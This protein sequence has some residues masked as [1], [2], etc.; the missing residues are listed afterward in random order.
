MKQLTVFALLMAQFIQAGAQNSYT[1]HYQKAKA[2]ITAM[3][4]GQKPL[5]FEK[6]VFLMENAYYDNSIEYADFEVVLDGYVQDVKLIA[7]QTGR[8]KVKESKNFTTTTEQYQQMQDKAAD[9]FAIFRFMTDTSFRL[10]SLDSTRLHFLLQRRLPF[11]YP[12]YDPLGSND[13]KNTQVLNLAINKTGNCFALSALFKMLADRLHTG[14][15]LCTAPGHIYIRHADEKGT[16]FNVELAT[17]SFPGTGSLMTLTY[18]TT[19][20][21]KSGIALRQL[22]EKQSVAL[23]LVYLA[24]GHQHRFNKTP[25]DFMLDCAETALRFDSLNLNALLLKAEVLENR[26]VQSG[27]NI[28]FLRN[29]A[30]FKAY[31]GLINRLYALGYREMPTDMKNIIVS[32]FIKDSVYLQ[33]QD[34]TPVA[35]KGNKY[36]TRYASLSWGMFEEVHTDKPV[37]QYGST[38]F[39]TKAKG[40]TGFKKAD[41]L[42]NGYDFDPV[43]FAWNI[44]PLAAKYPNMSPYNAFANNPILF[45]D[46]G[47]DTF[48][49][50]YEE[51]NAKTGETRLT[52]VDFNGVTAIAESGAVYTMGTN[53]FVD[54]VIS[55]YNYIVENGADVKGVLKDIA[56]RSEITNVVLDT[57]LVDPTRYVPDEK[58]P[59]IFFNPYSGLD[60][61][62]DDGSGGIQSA[63]VG[64][65]HEVV[66]RFIE[67]NYTDEQKK[68]LKKLSNRQTGIENEEFEVLDSYETPA[69]LILQSAGKKEAARQGYGWGVLETW[70][71]GPTSTEKS[72]RKEAKQKLETENETIV[73]S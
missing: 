65:F 19:Q 70:T 28:Q 49:I 36:Q 21:I 66:H 33:V 24:K 4:E 17:A 73:K 54:N 44:D 48:R 67:L 27:Q 56:S 11:S 52:Y 68:E 61:K 45:V 31:E 39:D 34:H 22:N 40:I 16:L 59:T 20:A 15:Q 43:V 5:D 63:A 9:N 8:E 10:F 38:L 2:E 30:D 14:A 46:P 13:W 62:N 25:D 23:C 71:Q 6:A 53:Q 47:G 72:T 58:Q 37:E 32:S 26:L 29:H 1:G 42:Y 12:T 50:Y 41:A 60:I 64:F 69:V 18:T 55:S 35:F 3:L 51:T 57:R 7:A